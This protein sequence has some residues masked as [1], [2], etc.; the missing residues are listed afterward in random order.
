MDFRTEVTNA[1]RMR[2]FLKGNKSVTVPRRHVGLSTERMIVMEWIQ[3]R[4]EGGT[5]SVCEPAHSLP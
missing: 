2:A 5:S 3:V 4:L 1:N